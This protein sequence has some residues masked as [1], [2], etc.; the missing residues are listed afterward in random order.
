MHVQMSPFVV[1]DE[2]QG[3]KWKEQDY[4]GPWHI[5]V[6]VVLLTL[7]VQKIKHFR[8]S[9]LKPDLSSHYKGVLVME[10]DA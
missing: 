7:M 5:E 4:L 1:G 2:I 8:D 9:K 10:G 6:V 3:G